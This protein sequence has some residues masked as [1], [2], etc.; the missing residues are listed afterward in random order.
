VALARANVGKEAVENVD[1]AVP[2]AKL[3]PVPHRLITVLLLRDLRSLVVGDSRDGLRIARKTQL[4][5]SRPY[6]FI[7]RKSY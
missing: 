5:H 3:E 4:C 2:T 7:T 6:T 1:L